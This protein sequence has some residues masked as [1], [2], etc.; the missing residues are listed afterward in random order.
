MPVC[1]VYSF[2]YAR[3]S[4]IVQPLV[5]CTICIDPAFFFCILIRKSTSSK[6]LYKSFVEYPVFI[7][8]I[9]IAVK[10]SLSSKL[11]YIT[12]NLISDQFN[13]RFCRN[14]L[15]PA[16]LP[17]ANILSSPLLNPPNSFESMVCQPVLVPPFSV[18]KLRNLSAGSV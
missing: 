1:T 11:T 14:I 18:F 12:F 2:K 15:L 4:F 8:S 16:P 13:A 10:F 3:I 7:A 5:N 9:R 6:F 17:P